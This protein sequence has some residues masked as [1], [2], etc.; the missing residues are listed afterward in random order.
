MSADN[1]TGRDGPLTGLPVNTCARARPEPA[2]SAPGARQWSPGVYPVSLA[3][4]A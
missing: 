2:Q 4:V 1:D 3:I